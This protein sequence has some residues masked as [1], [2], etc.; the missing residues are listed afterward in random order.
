LGAFTKGDTTAL[1]Y[2]R[3]GEEVETEITF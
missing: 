1:V 3:D 2:L